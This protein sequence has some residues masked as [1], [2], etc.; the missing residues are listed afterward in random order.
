MTISV[1]GAV[2]YYDYTNKQLLSK[3]LDPVFGVLPAPVNV[4]K[5]EVKGAELAIDWAPFQELHLGLSGDYLDA[6]VTQY[7]GVNQNGVL[8]N[9]GG[10]AM[11]FTPGRGRTVHGLP[12]PRLAQRDQA[13]RM[14]RLCSVAHDNRTWTMIPGHR[15]QRLGVSG[16]RH[17]LSSGIHD[18][19]T[20][21]NDSS[22]FIANIHHRAAAR[23][24]ITSHRSSDRAVQW[25]GARRRILWQAS[26][27]GNLEPLSRRR[28]CPDGLD[29]LLIDA[30]RACH[31]PFCR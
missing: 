3:I 4:P 28:E 31:A 8:A 24:T 25:G 26:R 23:M 22:P 14:P 9:F 15:G 30:R 21:D 2:F 17:R 10:S 29:D 1:N 12:Q 5:S 27:L 18:E 13:L 16:A 19:F 6:T 7:T 20:R 11:P